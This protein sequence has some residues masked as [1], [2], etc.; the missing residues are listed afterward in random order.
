MCVYKSK[1][2]VIKNG[3]FERRNDPKRFT[4]HGISQLHQEL[5]L[6]SWERGF[7]DPGSSCQLA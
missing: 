3:H 5:W 4:P 1:E 2:L 6:A 7:M